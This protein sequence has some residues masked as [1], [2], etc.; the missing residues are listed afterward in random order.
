MLAISKNAPKFDNP[1]G[2][3]GY[4]RY[5]V[6]STIAMVAWLMVVVASQQ[7]IP[8][9]INIAAG[10]EW[11]LIIGAAALSAKFYLKKKLNIVGTAM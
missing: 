1:K 2:Q 8:S 6:V 9:F 10:Y 3:R 5:L 4:I 11:Y 7:F